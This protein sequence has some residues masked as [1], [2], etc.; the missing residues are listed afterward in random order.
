MAQDDASAP[1][2]T[3]LDVLPASVPVEMPQ[4][5]ATLRISTEAQFKALGDPLRARI[6]RLVQFRA[7]TAKQ[8]A[9]E[10]GSSP[11][12]MGHH[13]QVLEDARLVQIVAR[14]LIN[15][16]TVA[17]YYARTAAT[18]IL[19]FPPELTGDTPQE[20]VLLDQARDELLAA[21][22]TIRAGNLLLDAHFPHRKLSRERM[23]EY[24]RRLQR[25]VDDFLAETDDPEGNVYGLFI[26]TFRAPPP[27]APD[28]G[29]DDSAAEE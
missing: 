24:L 12:A 1:V 19:D 15:N 4:L 20:L 11:G 13:L 25:L 5:P 29:K 27:A 2:G 7:L 21:L 8:L 10:L 28:G 14:R 6:L 16:L 26:T 3:P 18:Y 23:I 17:K 22:P 9:T